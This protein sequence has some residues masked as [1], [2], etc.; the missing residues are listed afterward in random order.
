LLPPSDFPPGYGVTGEQDSGASL[1]GSRAGIDLATESCSDFVSHSQVAVL[2][3]TAYAAEGLRSRDHSVEYLQS[4]WQFASPA[5]AAGVYRD[6][7]ALASRCPETSLTSGGVAEQVTIQAQ[8]RAPIGGH[9]SVEVDET[10]SVPGVAGALVQ[11]TLW[12]AGGA[13]LFGVVIVTSTQQAPAP[14]S[15]SLRT[16]MNDLIARVLAAR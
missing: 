5:G 6:V 2:G 9:G 15:P 7:R 8:A 10:V 16:L 4:I 13:D 1:A 14:Q 3:A 12:S 11:K